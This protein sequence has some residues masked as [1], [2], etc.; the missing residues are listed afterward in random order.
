VLPTQAPSSL[1]GLKDIS[2]DI[3]IPN[4]KEAKLHAAMIQAYQ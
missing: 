3:Y 4:P 2:N 1:E